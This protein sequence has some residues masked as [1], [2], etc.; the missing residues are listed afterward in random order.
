[1][2]FFTIFSTLLLTA[3]ALPAPHNGEVHDT[4]TYTIPT[5][6]TP[7]VPSGHPTKFTPYIFRFPRPKDG[8]TAVDTE[9]ILTSLQPHGFNKSHLHH[10]Y[11]TLMNGF[12]ADMSDH[13]VK[14]LKAMLPASGVIIEPIREYKIQ[15]PLPVYTPQLADGPTFARDHPVKQARQAPAPGITDLQTQTN[16]PWGL[17]RISQKGKIAAK[18]R[19]DISVGQ[20]IFNYTFDENAGDGVDI[21]VLDTGVN[22]DHQSFGGRADRLWTAS[23]FTGPGSQSPE[24]IARGLGEGEEDRNGHGTHCAGTTGSRGFGVAKKA[25]IHAIKVLGGTAGS[26]NSSDIVA[27]IE[28]MTIRHIQRKK[29][30]DFKGS[31][32]SMSFGVDIGEFDGTYSALEE[33]VMRASAAGIHIVIAAGNSN[34]DA[35][36][37]S[38]AFLSNKIHND[39]DYL[40]QAG[41]ITVGAS[42]INDERAE[43]SNYGR[44]ITTYAPG[45]SIL[46]TSI[47]SR[48]N[49]GDDATKVMDGTSMAAPHISGLVAYLLGQDQS[50]RTDVVAMK[51]KIMNMSWK[52]VLDP[53]GI[54][55][56]AGD[57]QIL[58]FNGV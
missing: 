34:D 30:S 16:A 8:S 31:V 41:V 56:G 53:K 6:D 15:A 26:G 4:P 21:Y 49:P 25:N 54:P 35:C 32:A 45:K 5:G 44:C 17:Q 33:A 55:N 13:C 51:K 43:F 10:K 42:T 22:I 50:L 29:Q 40:Y 36:H 37:S 38:P 46:S 24:D 7:T 57:T 47:T 19:T 18:F 58:A 14:I 27:G 3:S 11:S 28:F 20:A 2:H 9:S 1:M 23:G 12:S 39:T 52:G 48:E